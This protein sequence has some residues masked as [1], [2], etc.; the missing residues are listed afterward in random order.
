[1]ILFGMIYISFI[2]HEISVTV[3]ELRLLASYIQN[4]EENVT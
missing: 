3:I 2:L 1:M 4:I